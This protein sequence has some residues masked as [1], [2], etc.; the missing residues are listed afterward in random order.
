M[1]VKQ[2]KLRGEERSTYLNTFNVDTVEVITTSL[3]SLQGPDKA[4]VPTYDEISDHNQAGHDN[5]KTMSAGLHQSL[6]LF[7]FRLSFVRLSK[8]CSGKL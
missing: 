3:F 6:F 5:P 4:G 2:F 7:Y 1:E 8:Y